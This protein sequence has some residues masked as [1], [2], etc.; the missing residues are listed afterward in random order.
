MKHTLLVTLMLASQFAWA[1]CN[2]KTASLLT[3]TQ[4]VGPIQ[5]L[6][7]IANDGKCTVKF[8]VNVN[9]KWHSVTDSISDSHYKGSAL[10]SHAI[11][12]GREKL[13]VSLGGQFNSESITVCREGQ[14]V[15]RKI[16][17]GDLILETEVGQSSVKWPEDRKYNNMRC[18]NFTE[19]YFELGILK[20]YFGVICQANPND[21][22]WMVMAKW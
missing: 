18:R 10:C 9:G 13:L 22:M 6:V 19:Q 14:K 12:Q 11:R 20:R 7:E 1:N 5:N 2:V 15:E 17:V 3:D 4:V 8:D 21:P 16:K